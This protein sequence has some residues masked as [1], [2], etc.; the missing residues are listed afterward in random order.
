MLSGT[1]TENCL[2][3]VY[4]RCFRTF[5][6]TQACSKINETFFLKKKGVFIDAADILVKFHVV[7]LCFKYNMFENESSH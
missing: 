7:S 1:R 4:G 5:K 6:I 3:Q 2:Y